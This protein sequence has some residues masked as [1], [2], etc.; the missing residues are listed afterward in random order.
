VINVTDLKMGDILIKKEGDHPKTI[1]YIVTHS[2]LPAVDEIYWVVIN[3]P[4]WIDP[5]KTWNV[6]LFSIFTVAVG[7]CKDKYYVTTIKNKLVANNKS[8]NKEYNLLE[9]TT[10][11]KKLIR[12]L[13]SKNMFEIDWRNKEVRIIEKKELSKFI[14]NDMESIEIP[15][16]IDGKV[17]YLLMQIPVKTA[18]HSG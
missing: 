16:I 17:F 10:L 1:N 11:A 8:I 5:A 6:Q 13:S 18:T 2:G 14:G 12:L 3:E 15:F 4:I 7:R 9:D